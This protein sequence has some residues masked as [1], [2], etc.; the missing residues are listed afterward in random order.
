MSVAID[1]TAS[2]GDRH[3]LSDTDMNEYEIAMSQVGKI[4][5]NYS[6]KKK[7]SGYGFGGIPNGST[8]GKNV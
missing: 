2:N 7:F 5:E 8:D 4:L 3:N 6:Y 1:F